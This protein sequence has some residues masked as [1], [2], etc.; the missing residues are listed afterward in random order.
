LADAIEALLLDPVRAKALG[1]Q[2]R[3]AVFEKFGVERMTREVLAV[4]E[5]ISGKYVHP[6]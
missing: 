6:K 1:D 2:G 4:F 5:E 3:K